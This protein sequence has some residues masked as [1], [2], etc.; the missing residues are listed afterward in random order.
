MDYDQDFGIVLH[1]SQKRRFVVEVSFCEHY[2]AQSTL[3]PQRPS[4]NAIFKIAF[5]AWFIFP[6]LSKD[7]RSIN[8]LY[9]LWLLEALILIPITRITITWDNIAD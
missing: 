3:S 9:R 6:I 2:K 4:K 5:W 1:Y 7:P 8:C